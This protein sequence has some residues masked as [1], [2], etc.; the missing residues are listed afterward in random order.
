MCWIALHAQQYHRQHHTVTMVTMWR[1]FYIYSNW[2]ILHI[3]AQNL[4]QINLLK[5]F[6]V[7]LLYTL[8]ILNTC[9]IDCFCDNTTNPMTSQLCHWW[10]HTIVTDDV[11]THFEEEIN[12]FSR[13]ILFT[14][15]QVYQ[16]KDTVST[17]K[18]P[19]LYIEL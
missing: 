4:L 17:T 2:K 3:F 8:P 7:S 6:D 10:C 9:Y 14:V 15:T 18:S 13:N 11:I 5:Y 19:E 16:I 1:H 12:Y